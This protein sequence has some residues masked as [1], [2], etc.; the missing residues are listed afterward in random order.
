MR[1]R[2]L[3]LVATACALAGGAAIAIA[4]IPD[5][6]GVI[7]G[8]YDPT[9]PAP[10]QLSVVDSTSECK[11]NAVVLPF[12]QTGPPGAPGPTGTRGPTGVIGSSHRVSAAVTQTDPPDGAAYAGTATCPAGEV[13]LGGGFD[14]DE[15]VGTFDVVASRP[16]VDVRGWDV[17]LRLTAPIF[18][19]RG[20]PGVPDLLHLLNQWRHDNEQTQEALAHF[21][22]Q[23]LLDAFRHSGLGGTTVT[24]KEATKIAKAVGKGQARADTSKRA[25]KALG[26]AIDKSDPT[27]TPT[28]PGPVAQGAY[29][30]CGT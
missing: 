25:S 19:V 15:L 24:G 12:S 17:K 26:A 22:F 23:A 30:L 28:L 18:G 4:A 16:S 29:A 9:T 20:I 3:T 6:D 7:L 2:R 13:L 11:G 21:G 1:V 8:C 10:H 27:T 14:A 5:P